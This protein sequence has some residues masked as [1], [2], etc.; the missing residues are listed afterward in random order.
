[1]KKSKASEHLTNMLQP[2]RRFT[3]ATVS[4]KL[5]V[6]RQTVAAWCSGANKPQAEHAIKLEKLLGI[7]LEEWVSPVTT[8]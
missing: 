7:T 5:G 1:M 4:R 8:D 3:I 2:K 6:S